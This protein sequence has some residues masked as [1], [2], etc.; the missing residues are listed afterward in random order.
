MYRARIRR[1]WEPRA[2][3]TPWTSWST[4][5]EN[6]FLIRLHPHFNCSCCW[7]AGTLYRRLEPSTPRSRLAFLGGGD[8]IFRQLVSNLL[9]ADQTLGARHATRRNPTYWR[10]ARNGN[11][12]LDLGPISDASA[13]SHLRQEFLFQWH[14]LHSL[15]RYRR[16]STSS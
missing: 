13:H 15:T 10:M 2:W 5:L 6:S 11:W 4:A 1:I 12:N 9:S 3:Y 8:S 14:H 16:S 7:L